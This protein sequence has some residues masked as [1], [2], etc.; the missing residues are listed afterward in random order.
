M[1]SYRICSGA[2]K[3]EKGKGEG[4]SELCMSG[5]MRAPSSCMKPC[6]HHLNYYYDNNNEYTGPHNIMH[7][8]WVIHCNLKWL[9]D[10]TKFISDGL[11]DDNM[12]DEVSLSDDDATD[13][14]GFFSGIKDRAA[15]AT[16]NYTAEKLKSDWIHFGETIEFDLQEEIQDQKTRWWEG[17]E[18]LDRSQGERGSFGRSG[19]E[20]A[21]DTESTLPLSGGLNQGHQLTNFT[22][23][24]HPYVLPPLPSPTPSPQHPF[25][26]CT[27][28]R[29]LAQ[30][31]KFWRS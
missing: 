27:L 9:K 23:T 25:L 19:E 31:S 13:K 24:I 29:S 6:H 2:S 8:N 12:I 26:F 4:R 22:F 10:E 18:V 16:R 11:S 7:T 20:E 5:D 17:D 21:R 28:S 15:K 1:V 30:D 14:G 3:K